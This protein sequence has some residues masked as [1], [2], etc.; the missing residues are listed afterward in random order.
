M[1]A[2]MASIEIYI[3]VALGENPSEMV[4]SPC[5][6][7]QRFA[8]TALNIPLKRVVQMANF[9]GFT[10]ECIERILEENKHR[11]T[12]LWVTGHPGKLA[13]VLDGSWDTHSQNSGSAVSTLCQIGKEFGFAQGVLSQIEQSRT[14]QGV[15]DLLESEPGASKFWSMIE[16]RIGKLISERLTR[17]EQ[18]T[19]RLFQMDGT[20][21]GGLA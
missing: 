5:N 16:Q 12:R 13:K 20:A 8:R 18:V 2:F 19:V 1:A 14:V 17:V 3:R 7:G 6:L 21:L 10:L 11:L 9:V 4:I 15:I